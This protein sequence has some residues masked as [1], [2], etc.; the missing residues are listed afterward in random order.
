MYKFTRNQLL[1]IIKDKHYI[2]VEDLNSFSTFK[3]NLFINKEINS[4]GIEWSYVI[5]ENRLL[6]VL[7]CLDIKRI[8]DDSQDVE[9]ELFNKPNYEEIKLLFLK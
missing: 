9:I 6:D 4:N 3:Y 2:H 1:N 5:S 8:R 7:M